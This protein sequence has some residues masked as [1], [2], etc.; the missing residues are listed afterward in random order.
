MLALSGRKEFRW[1]AGQQ[2]DRV[3]V[4]DRHGL[5]SSAVTHDENAANVAVDD[6]EQEGKLHLVLT[7]DLREGERGVP[8][9]LHGRDGDGLG[10]GLCCCAHDTPA[11]CHGAGACPDG[12]RTGP[13]R[14]VLPANS[15]NSSV[16]LRSD[17]AATRDCTPN[18]GV[19]G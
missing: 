16:G 19:S 5:G 6:V 9:C 8:G 1:V 18:L 14:A 13:C 3:L 15:I 2:G 11:D 12:G 10:R 7:N 4:P 17:A